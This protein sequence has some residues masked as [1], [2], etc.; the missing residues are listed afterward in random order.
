MDSA[1]DLPCGRGCPIRIPADQR[2]LAPPRSF[3]QRATSFIASWRQG[4]H[5]MPLPKRLIAKPVA[6][7]DKPR[8]TTSLAFE[9]DLLA[10]E[11]RVSP[12]TDG[13]DRSSSHSPGKSHATVLRRQRRSPR[14]SL[15]TCQR[16]KTLPRAHKL[17]ANTA[18]PDRTAQLLARAGRRPVLPQAL[19]QLSYTPRFLG[20]SCRP[21]TWGRQRL[22]QQAREPRRAR[23]NT[24]PRTRCR[25]IR[26]SSSLHQAA[27]AVAG[28]TAAA[29]DTN[30]AS[31]V[32]RS[33]WAREDLNLRPHAY[34]ARALT[35]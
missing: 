13:Q 16:S 30:D 14:Y 17:K 9:D 22:R 12:P 34:Q 24:K 4:I 6:R 35:N 5:Q 15:F 18:S 31:R 27:L 19:S 26:R 2:A 1:Q 23:Q 8:R 28:A 11:Q 25:A 29:D 10:L 3:S 33:W 20:G 7:R 32:V 21:K